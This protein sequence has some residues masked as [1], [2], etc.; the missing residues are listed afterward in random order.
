L[1]TQAG[2]VEVK[3]TLKADDFK[4]V[5][6]QSQDQLKGFSDGAK[7]FIGELGKIFTFAA[8]GKFFKDSLD[9][10]AQQEL[11]TAK[12]IKAM[13]NQGIATREAVDHL[14][15]YATALQSATGVQ[16][17]VIN[18]AQATLV[19]F[20]L[21]GEALDKTTKAALD[22]SVAMGIDLTQAATLLGK[23][24]VGET[25]T[26]SR[27]GIIID[28][29]IPST[30]K[31][32]SALGQVEKRFGGQAQAAA[33]TFSGQLKIMGAAFGELQEA[34]GKLL[35]NEGGGIIPMITKFINKFTEAL[36]IIANARAQFMSLGDFLKTFAITILGSIVLSITRLV[37]KLYEM[38]A[39]V[40]VLGRMYAALGEGIKR[41]ND[42]IEQQVIDLTASKIQAAEAA[43]VMKTAEN[44][45][46]NEFKNTHETLVAY[47][48][49]E[50]M[51]LKDKLADEIK[52]R[53][54]QEKELVAAREEFAN[55]FKTTDADMWKFST[56]LAQGF[57]DDFGQ[58]LARMAFENEKFS[59]VIKKLWQNMAKAIIAEIGRMIAKWLAFLA[60]RG[61][62]SAFGGPIGG[63]AMSFATSFSGTAATGG[64]INEPSIL[65]GLRSGRS[66]L[67]GEAGPETIVPGGTNV[68]GS[69]GG[70][71]GG[72]TINISGQFLEGDE[73]AWQ[74]MMRERIVPEVRRFTM[75]V[76]TG[77]FNRRR[78][79]A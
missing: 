44:D 31:F 14:A 32:A 35:A 34:V 11:A 15:D 66:I 27:Y 2:E 71:R 77:P 43:G 42:W 6:G 4:K 7:A 52:M 40:P 22:M 28:K 78:G 25:G 45:K 12:L 47:R 19:S 18:G 20:G 13:E 46:R 63:G 8:I 33:N 57:F 65:T 56:D 60:L 21:Q 55:A 68:A 74:K 48:A 30:E 16:D 49:V 10:Y 62:A 61:V 37:E 5:M 73:A 9:A 3:L 75:S 24:F 67:T 41:T 26:L 23:A 29:N 1:A 70:M 36:N 79:S 39:N 58:G 72:V 69:D 17:E 54:E 53:Q 50:S 38:M 51:E 64:Q 59:D 76:P